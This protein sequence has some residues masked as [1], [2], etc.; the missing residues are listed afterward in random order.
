MS[1]TDDISLNI[2][3]KGKQY[4]ISISPSETW[5]TLQE[6]LYELTSIPPALQKLLFKGK[7]ATIEHDDMLELAGIKDG[8]KIMLLGSTEAEI[9][10]VKATEAEKKRRDEIMKQR[11]AR[12][13]TKVSDSF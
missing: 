10:S 11:A 2:T 3:Y 1:T 4:A 7:K 6:R 9:G 8:M 5:A 12:G 13:P